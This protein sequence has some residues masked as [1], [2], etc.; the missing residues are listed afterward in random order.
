MAALRAPRQLGGGASAHRSPPGGRRAS[1]AA[2]GRPRRVGWSISSVRPAGAPRVVPRRRSAGVG[3]PKRPS[4][5]APSLPGVS[6]G[7]RCPWPR[8][9]GDLPHVDSVAASSSS[10]G[11]PSCARIARK[12]KI[13][14][15]AGRARRRRGEQR[16]GRRARVRRSLG[17][18]GP[19]SSG[20]SPSVSN[21]MRLTRP[22][23]PGLVDAGGRATSSVTL[24]SSASVIDPA[25]TMTATDRRLTVPGAW[26]VVSTAWLRAILRRS[27]RGCSRGRRRGGRPT[28]GCPVAEDAGVPP[29]PGPL[30][31][32]LGSSP[33]CGR[34]L[35]WGR[36]LVRLVGG[37]A[38]VEV[39][40]GRDRDLRLP[41]PERRG[42]S[43]RWRSTRS[44]RRSWRCLVLVRRAAGRRPPPGEASSW[45]LLSATVTRSGERPWMPEATRFVMAWTSPSPIV[46]DVLIITDAEG[47]LVVEGEHLVLGE[48]EVHG[49][50]LDAGSW[51][52]WSSP[53]RPPSPAGSRPAG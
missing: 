19:S 35:G 34:R 30:R 21:G 25:S 10:G 1:R 32:G 7:C 12:A 47:L 18:R 6:A 26:L 37:L 17:P 48:G 49:R 40:V 23:R 9:R 31:L 52:R 27:P 33:P 8:G 38:L 46:P 43:T 22:G 51:P 3:T 53:S 11:R 44:S 14:D 15:R 2:S 4:T 36:R 28:C 16:D 29:A 5:E 41:G 39:E 20:W 42:G 24:A 13:S 50:G 45:P